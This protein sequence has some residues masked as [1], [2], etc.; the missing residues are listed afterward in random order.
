M[1]LSAKVEKYK[2]EKKAC[3]SC[4]GAR[5]EAL[6]EAEAKFNERREQ[7]PRMEDKNN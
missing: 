6:L 4:L 3:E 5:Q 2:E 1:V 7:F